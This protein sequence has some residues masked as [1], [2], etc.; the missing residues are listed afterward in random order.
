MGSKEEVFEKQHNILIN[1]DFEVSRY[2]LTFDEWDACVED[3]GCAA[4]SPSSQN[5]GRG[6]QPVI[7]VSWLDAQSYIA[8]LNKRTGENYRLLT[9]A[10]FE[11]VARAGTTTAYWW[12]DD[13]AGGHAVCVD[14][15]SPWDQAPGRLGRPPRL[16]A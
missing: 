3:G 15:G 16:A 10:E 6:R 13:V 1:Y 7:N 4:Y 12:G 11:Y 14:C 2:L 9:E 8:W 5:W